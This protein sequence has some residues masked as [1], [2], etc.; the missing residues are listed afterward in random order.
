MAT[1][2]QSRFHGGTVWHLKGSLLRTPSMQIKV[3]MY[4]LVCIAECQVLKADHAPLRPGYRYGIVSS[5]YGRCPA[6]PSYPLCSDDQWVSEIHCTDYSQARSIYTQ[7][8]FKNVALILAFIVLIFTWGNLE[9][10]NTVYTAHINFSI[11]IFI[12]CMH[13]STKMHLITV[14]RHL[15]CYNDSIYC[16]DI[17]ACECCYIE[18]AT[19]QLSW[20]R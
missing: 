2:C 9:M 20:Q 13:N 16:F 7:S 18:V 1:K 14:K 10:K 3:F 12:L 17:I 19:M 8:I 6:K 4:M 11:S 5:R 15:P